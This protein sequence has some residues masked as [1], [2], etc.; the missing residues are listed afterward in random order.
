MGNQTQAIHREK[1]FCALSALNSFIV[2]S[3]TITLVCLDI[4]NK[5]ANF[6]AHGVF[7]EQNRKG[8]RTKRHESVLNTRRG[9]VWAYRLRLCP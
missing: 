8:I 2:A 9:A 3:T 7:T 1:R 4:A 5:I 6:T